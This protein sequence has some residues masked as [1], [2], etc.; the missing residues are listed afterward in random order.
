MAVIDNIYIDEPD[1]YTRIRV[2]GIQCDREIYIDTSSRRN[3][4]KVDWT[5][6]SSRD[7]LYAIPLDFMPEY[8]NYRLCNVV[9]SMKPSG[10]I[11]IRY[12]N[13]NTLDNRKRNLVVEAKGLLY[14]EG[15]QV[16]L[17]DLNVE[18]D[19]E[20]TKWLVKVTIDGREYKDTEDADEY[21]I[22]EAYKRVI[23]KIRYHY[24]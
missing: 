23:K 1:G 19:E 17:L 3:V 16:F 10:R 13:G 7:K 22:E 21:P 2:K 9:L 18:L 15:A 20:S 14:N 12:K 4:E 5:I 11:N 8:K 6:Q 24:L